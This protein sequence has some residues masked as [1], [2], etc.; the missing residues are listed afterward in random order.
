[1]EP[2]FP[3][4]IKF[5]VKNTW[6]SLWKVKNFLT[7]G[8]TEKTYAKISQRDEKSKK[9]YCLNGIIHVINNLIQ[10]KNPGFFVGKKEN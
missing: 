10:C 7:Y 4:N 6:F 9:I 5:G 1:M 8:S 2:F 3:Q